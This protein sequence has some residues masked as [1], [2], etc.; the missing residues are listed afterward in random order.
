LAAQYLCRLPSWKSSPP[1]GLLSNISIT[2]QRRKLDI[3]SEKP[4]MERNDTDMQIFKYST[5]FKTFVYVITFI[6]FAFDIFIA[7][8]LF[9]D[10]SMKDSRL[11]GFELFIM[12]M[13]CGI[14]MVTII[15]R[16]S[17]MVR[18]SASG[19]SLIKTSGFQNTIQWSEITT[20]KNS[21]FMGRLEIH[22]ADPQRELFVEHQIS[23]FADLF[24]KIQE[25]LENQYPNNHEVITKI[26]GNLFQPPLEQLPDQELIDQHRIKALDSAKGLLY[27]GL[28]F[29]LSGA[30]LMM[31]APL[32]WKL[33]GW[34]MFCDG[35]LLLAIGQKERLSHRN[36]LTVE[37]A[38]EKAAKSSSIS[39][40]SKEAMLG[41]LL[42]AIFI[43]LCFGGM[44]LI[45]KLAS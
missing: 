1:L 24:S 37:E 12:F 15:P 31:T 35:C 20:I 22:S 16:L 2:D 13:L 8:S 38:N 29:I 18:V 7:Y 21:Q 44:V 6:S 23:G 33:F 5:R 9:F 4:P 28:F 32:T 36:R 45:I 43:L 14:T 25:H 11:L 39:H 26:S 10:A 19:I 40:W 17:D 42:A 27:I 34:F 41:V 3:E 30:L